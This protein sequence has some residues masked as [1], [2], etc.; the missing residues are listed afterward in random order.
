MDMT[1]RQFALTLAAAAYLRPSLFESLSP[2][3]VPRGVVPGRAHIDLITR[4]LPDDIAVDICYF[5]YRS[6]RAAPIDQAVIIPGSN[7]GELAA[8]DKYIRRRPAKIADIDRVDAVIARTGELVIARIG[9]PQHIPEK[10]AVDIHIAAR[11]VDIDTRGRQVEY[12]GKGQPLEPDIAGAGHAYHIGTGSSKPRSVKNRQLPRIGRKNKMMAVLTTMAGIDKKER[13]GRIKMIGPLS[14]INSHIGA[15]WLRRPPYRIP[16]IVP[17][18]RQG[19]GAIH[20]LINIYIVG[21]RKNTFCA[22]E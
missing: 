4:R 3:G 2:L 21:L 10:T 11:T 16:E 6:H 8:V 19:T 9:A 22:K 12:I 14:E 5:G 18:I 20:W 1:R 7:R 15:G 17:W 13:V